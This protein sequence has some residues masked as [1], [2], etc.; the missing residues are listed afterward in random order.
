[1]ASSYV[2][3]LRLN[4]MATGDASGSWGTNTNTN[5]S[6]IGEALGY[7]TEGITTNANTHTTTVADGATDPG[8][9]MYIEYTGTL[10]SAC[11]ITIAPN[12]LSRMHF[13]ENGTSGSQ[14]IIIK[15][16]SGATITIPP[17]DTKAVYLDGAG[18]GAKVV[19]AFASLNVV[20]LKV[21]DDLTVTDDA[22]IGGTLGVTGVL[23]ATSLDISGAIDVDGTS[24]LDVVDIDGAVDMASTLQVDGAITNSSTIVSA[25]KIT[26]DAGIDIDNF[27]ID[28]T[29]IALSS[30]DIT[31]DSAGRVDLSA[32]DNGEVRLFDGSLHYGQF[33]EDS[34]HFLIQ[35]V[36]ADADI[37]I[38]GLDDST[39]VNAV[40]F[41]MSD[42]GRAIFPAGVTVHD[43]TAL[44]NTTF[45]ARDVDNVTSL[46][47]QNN[48]AT[49]QRSQSATAAPTLVFNKARGSL[50]SEANVN[51]GDFTGSITFRGYHT[52][53]FYQ[54]ATIESK[55]SGTH[56]TSD[57]PGTLLFATSN[58]GSATP[59]SRMEIDQ[60]GVTK[61]TGGVQSG[62]QDLKFNN[63]T[64]SLAQGATYTLTDILNTGALIS[65]GQNRSN[66]GIT[67]DH[68]LIFGETGTAAT[69]VANPS[70]RFAINSA[71]TSNQTNIFVN[72]GSVVILNEVGTTVTYTIAAFVYQGN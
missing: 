17:G 34:N 27:N 60:A 70:G 59:T 36:V 64:V 40:Q 3:D 52:N 20:D 53:G 39:I 15:Q 45:D 51:N 43:A 48:A 22:T 21:Q 42:A 14:N 35:S 13:I 56:G 69:V 66:Q 8:R 19:D 2:N 47:V 1:M 49:I 44:T 28:G 7:G 23:T 50:G 11:T 16:G 46:N 61:L 63:G 67:Y 68:C 24:N 31:L 65:I 5:L 37:Y 4:E 54:T 55:V 72:S 33:K 9:A 71:T 57:M 10:D 62:R 6:L 32:D 30:G 18:S 29:T 38:Q 25:G 58:D 26:A 41:D 12:T